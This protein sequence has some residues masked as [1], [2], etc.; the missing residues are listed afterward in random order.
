[1]A[2]IHISAPRAGAEVVI[3]DGS[4]GDFFVDLM[5]PKLALLRFIIQ[6]EDLWAEVGGRREHFHFYSNSRV[7][8]GAAFRAVVPR[9]ARSQ[10]G[11]K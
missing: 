2:T 6:R 7:K 1:M 11:P 9:L 3:E 5:I 8:R 4:A 10:T